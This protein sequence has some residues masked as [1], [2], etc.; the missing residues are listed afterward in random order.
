MGLP[1]IVKAL[2]LLKKHP[3]Y[4][5]ALDQMCYVRP[6]LERYPADMPAF[7]K[8][9]QEAPLQIADFGGGSITG[10][11]A[12]RSSQIRRLGELNPARL[13]RRSSGKLVA[14][15]MVIAVRY[16]ERMIVSIGKPIYLILCLGALQ[17]SSNSVAGQTS[18]PQTPRQ[19]TFQTFSLPRPSV[20]T[21]ATGINDRG[22]VV[23]YYYARGNQ[24]GFKRD[25]NG[26][27]EFPIIG[28]RD[29]V[30]TQPNAINDYGEIA[31]IFVDG[32]HGPVTGFLLMGGVHGDYTEVTG[33]P[34]V[35]AYVQGLNNLGDYVGS[36]YSSRQVLTSHGFVD[37]AGTRYPVDVP[38][39]DLNRTT[40]MA[41]A[42]DGT[43]VG[44]FLDPNGIDYGFLR[45][46]GG[47]FLAL[48][49]E[50]G[51]NTCALGINNRSHL[52]VGT[53]HG[54]DFRDHGFVWDYVEGLAD[55]SGDRWLRG[56]LI[57]KI[58][59]QVLDWPLGTLT[60]AS[61]NADGV[62]AGSVTP[63]EGYTFSFIA[64]PQN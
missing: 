12:R 7:R 23:G 53:F 31:G 9:L 13:F 47:R 38:P 11:S 62:I 44:C 3:D 54:K 16:T 57:L 35:S 45:G 15:N 61:V 48:Q 34:D 2:Y 1:H 63:S 5:F 37:T 36:Y 49:V 18:S 28:P 39:A 46:P 50:D 17:S 56:V 4:R 32:Q 6:F 10:R 24:Y 33:P 19:Y 40:P 58:R 29:A 41:V 60:A 20:A 55:P 26:V 14:R 51:S 22:A 27:M 25:A 8:F 64:T 43:I 59:P 21:I 52:I 42:A 30:R